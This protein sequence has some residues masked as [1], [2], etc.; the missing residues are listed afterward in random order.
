[1]RS[2]EDMFGVGGCLRSRVI[3]LGVGGMCKE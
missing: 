2:G 1:V 3:V